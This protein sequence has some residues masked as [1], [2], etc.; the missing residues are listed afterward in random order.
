M[1][2][3][4]GIDLGGTYVKLGLVD[5][6][7]AI[8]RRRSIPTPE[9]FREAADA[10]A[11][12]ARGILGEAGV[13]PG[14][15]PFAGIGVPST[16]HPLTGRLVLANNRGWQDAPLKEALEARLVLPVLV[17]ND[18]DCA[19]AGEVRAGAARGRHNVLLLTLGTGVGGGMLIE[20]R[21]YSGGDGM[22]MEV[23]HQPLIAG[24]WPCTCGARG[25]LE[26]YVS[27]TG[28]VR[29]TE[30][31]MAMHPDS[32]LHQ[33]QRPLSGQSAFESARAG[34]PAALRVLDTYSA[35]LAQ[36]IGGLVNV[37]RPEVVLLG[38]GVSHAGAPLLDRVNALL[39]RFI[40]AH[41]VIGGPPVLQATL[42]NDAG[43]IGAATLDI[44]QG[45]R[46]HVQ[47]P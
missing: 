1:S 6:D 22:G 40:L 47:V 12:A 16:V 28:L 31:T 19:L 45:R 39:P 9:D 2:L 8:V 46:E 24:G 25:C 11:A 23:G 14:A 33:A 5:D 32:L 36:G 17:A 37:F 15:L 30:E 3:R 44:V 10:I 35:W 20:D 42:G 29:L 18:A 41:E 4:L 26:C 7:C 21:L 13:E 38:G 34:D 27:A 43:I